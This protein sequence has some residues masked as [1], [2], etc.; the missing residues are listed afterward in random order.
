MS[1]RSWSGIC[2]REGVVVE[3]RKVNGVRLY[4]ILLVII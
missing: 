3:I 4:R 1:Y 2:K